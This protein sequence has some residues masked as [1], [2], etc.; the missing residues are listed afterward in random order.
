[1]DISTYYFGLELEFGINNI[2]HKKKSK[3]EDLI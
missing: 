3:Y 2:L 1:M